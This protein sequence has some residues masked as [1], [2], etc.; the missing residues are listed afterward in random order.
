MGHQGVG[1]RPPEEGEEEREEGVTGQNRARLERLGGCPASGAITR[2]TGQVLGAQASTRQAQRRGLHQNSGELGVTK[3]FVHAS[4]K[5]ALQAN[6]G[7]HIGLV[8]PGKLQ[9]MGPRSPTSLPPA[10]PP[11]PIP[12]PTGSPLSAC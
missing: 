10:S 9:W 11:Q 1:T 5:E 12:T 4:L 2:A 7:L 3:G 6:D 8:L